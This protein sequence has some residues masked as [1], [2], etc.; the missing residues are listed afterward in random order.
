MTL[1]YAFAG[2]HGS[3]ISFFFSPLLRVSWLLSVLPPH[4]PTAPDSR[5]YIG[6]KLKLDLVQGA[7]YEELRP[8]FPR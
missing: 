3:F 4:T 1:C 8:V 2:R 6:L 7:C 5:I